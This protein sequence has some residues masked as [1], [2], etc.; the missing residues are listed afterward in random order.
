MI[1]IIRWIKNNIMATVLVAIILVLVGYITYD[2]LL[3]NK[4]EKVPV[5]IDPYTT[6]KTLSNGEKI[7]IK[8]ATPP[9]KSLEEAGFSR[10]YV[11]NTLKKRLK[12]KEKD[13]KSVIKLE[14]TYEDKFY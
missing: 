7:D 9:T 3:N 4:I 6:R 2:K 13:I 12:L 11:D 1:Q 10:D 14:G 5:V 8:V